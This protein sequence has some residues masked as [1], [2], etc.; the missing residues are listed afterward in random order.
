M[1]LSTFYCGAL[2]DA[3]AHEHLT[4]ETQAFIMGGKP[5]TD[6]N[7]ANIG[8]ILSVIPNDDSTKIIFGH[9]VA[10]LLMTTHNPNGHNLVEI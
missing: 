1:V 2:L 6:M 3:G 9:N 4:E 7:R 10:L 8:L 5:D